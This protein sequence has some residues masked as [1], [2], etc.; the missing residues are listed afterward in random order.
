[1]ELRQ[2]VSDALVEI[3]EGVKDAKKKLSDEGGIN[4]APMGNAADYA[5]TT[6]FMAC[7]RKI[8]TFVDFD[9]AVTAAEGTGT[10]GGIGVFAGVVGLGSQGQSSESNSKVSRIRFQV[11]VLFP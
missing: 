9:V 11:P 4:P 8:A 2:F 3:F 6:G 7:G 10:K 1:M 5:G